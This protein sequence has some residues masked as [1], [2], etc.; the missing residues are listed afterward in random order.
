MV[1]TAGCG[2]SRH[3]AKPLQDVITQGALKGMQVGAQK[4]RHDPGEHHPCLALRTAR[5][6]DCRGRND[7]R[8]ELRLG[9]NASFERQYNT[10]DH[11]SC[12]EGRPVRRQYAVPAA[13]SLF[14][15]AQSPKPIFRFFQATCLPT[16]RTARL[17]PAVQVRE[18]T[19]REGQRQRGGEAIA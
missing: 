1:S 6:F 3:S 19:P 12:P 5:T 18:E 8:Q 11:R 9:H 7:R 17:S 15:I 2:A 16:K 13:G 4:C 14:N 10:L